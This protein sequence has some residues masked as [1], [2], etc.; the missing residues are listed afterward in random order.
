MSDNT[1]KDHE[2]M[3]DLG[4]TIDNDY[5]VLD[6]GLIK[7]GQGVVWMYIPHQHHQCTQLTTPTF[8][9]LL[10]LRD[11]YTKSRTTKA[12]QVNLLSRDVEN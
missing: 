12:K 6:S 11:R 3:V 5:R 4:E 9:I 8:R 2:N 1:I 10:R 7:Q